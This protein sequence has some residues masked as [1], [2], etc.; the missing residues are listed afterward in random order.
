LGLNQSPQRQ[1]LLSGDL[2]LHGYDDLTGICSSEL[3]DFMGRAFS[4]V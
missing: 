3:D 4:Q 2:R 1:R